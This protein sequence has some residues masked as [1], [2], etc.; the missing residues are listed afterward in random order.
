V[1]GQEKETGAGKRLFC[2]RFDN[3]LSLKFF[4]IENCRVFENIFTGIYKDDTKFL[5]HFRIMLNY[6]FNFQAI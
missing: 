2:V 6:H 1:S 3:G 4:F 5:L